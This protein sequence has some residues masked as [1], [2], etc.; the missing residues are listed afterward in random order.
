M[1]KV[2]IFIKTGHFSAFPLCKPYEKQPFWG[3]SEDFSGLPR[4]LRRKKRREL[5]AQRPAEGPEKEAN[6]GGHSIY[7]NRSAKLALPDFSVFSEGK[8]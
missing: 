1:K 7:I 3:I 5:R 6:E 4:A 8:L 2:V